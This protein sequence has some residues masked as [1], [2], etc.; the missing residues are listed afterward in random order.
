MAR[1]WID[2]NS[3]EV[4]AENEIEAMD[5]AWE[6]LKEDLTLVLPLSFEEIVDEVREE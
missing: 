5:K 3:F 4:E 1:Y 6:K 2:L